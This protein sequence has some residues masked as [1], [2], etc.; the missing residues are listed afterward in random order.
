MDMGCIKAVS[1]HLV[2]YK[3]NSFSAITNSFHSDGFSHRVDKINMELPI[4]YFK[5]LSV[6]TSIKLCFSVPEDYFYLAN[7]VDPDKMLLCYISFGS[8]LFAKEPVYYYPELA[9]K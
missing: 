5:G 6:K 4:L 8:S 7:S 3:I 9:S 1:Y 2:M